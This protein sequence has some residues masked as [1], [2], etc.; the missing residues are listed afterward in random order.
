MVDE[1]YERYRRLTHPELYRM[2][3]NGSSAQVAKVADTWASVADTLA[4]LAAGLRRDLDRLQPDWT[5]RGSREFHYRLDLVARYAQTLA[6]ESAAIRGGLT[7]MSHALREAQQRAETPDLV[8]R[9]EAPLNSDGVLGSSLGRVLPADAQAGAHERM[10]QVVAALAADYGVADHGNWPVALPD[11][12]L[13]LPAADATVSAGAS[14]L[15]DPRSGGTRLAAADGIVPAMRAAD[16]AAVSGTAT[17]GASPVR[18]ET[19]RHTPGYAIGHTVGH[20][21][22]AD[23]PAAAAARPG[24]ASPAGPAAAAPG[25]AGAPMTPMGMGP[26]AAMPS[27]MP[28]SAD[29]GAWRSAD[30]MDWAED[31]SETPPGVLGD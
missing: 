8:F 7:A 30:N 23:D 20:A 27:A 11:A 24:A 29:A 28:M 21:G 26:G 9:R 14:V 22:I 25:A 31:D 15:D 5:G 17:A 19:L 10:V 13:D 16:T 6:D 2:L 3:R 1:Y 12:P 4:T 18:V